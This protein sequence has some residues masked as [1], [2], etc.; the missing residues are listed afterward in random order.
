MAIDDHHKLEK[1]AIGP[2]V[3]MDDWKFGRWHLGS[4][5]GGAT[6]VYGWPEEEIQRMS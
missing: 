5:R 3:A 1:S 4:R 2:L 6:L